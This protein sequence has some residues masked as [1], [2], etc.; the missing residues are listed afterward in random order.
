MKYGKITLAEYLAN[1]GELLVAG[2]NNKIVAS[3]V[4]I[5]DITGGATNLE[6]L[7]DVTITSATSAEGLRV[8][9]DGVGFINGNPLANEVFIVVDEKAAST[10]GGTFLS[11]AWRTRDLNT[12][13][14]SQNWASLATNQI[15]LDPG[16]YEVRAKAPAYQVNQ[17]QLRFKLVSGGGTNEVLGSTGFAPRG[18]GTNSFK[19]QSSW[20]AGTIEV[21][22]SGGTYELQHRCVTDEFYSGFGFGVDNLFSLG[23][24]VYG[25]V[26][27][28]KKGK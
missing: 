2:A 9:V 18:T 5:N 14:E 6:D 16:T 3:G 10:A 22:G 13:H 24:N 4:L 21:S 26:E 1:E 15:S 12:I 7:T 25:Q 17:H 23:P 28:R 27:I 20:L 8:D 11:G 19:T